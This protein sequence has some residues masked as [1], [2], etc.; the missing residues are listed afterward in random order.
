MHQYERS[1]ER[2]LVEYRNLCCVQFAWT[3]AFEYKIIERPGWQDLFDYDNPAHAA[4]SH[5]Y[6]A[7]NLLANG[8]DWRNTIVHVQTAVRLLPAQGEFHLLE[9]VIHFLAD[10]TELALAEMLKAKALHCMD[11]A[12]DV[13]IHSIQKDMDSCSLPLGRGIVSRR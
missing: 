11:L 1:R 13:N 8:D 7:L 2:S 5:F 3:G 12:L 6:F 4:W 10:K 9:G